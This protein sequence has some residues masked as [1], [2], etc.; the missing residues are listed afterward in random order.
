MRLKIK[1][2][3]K[4]I[5]DLDEI[6]EDSALNETENWDSINHLIIVT[7]L[8]ESFSIKFSIT[9]IEELTTLDK[10]CNKIKKMI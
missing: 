4:E 8:E 1:K 5:L 6:S 2:I 9:D 10:I 7:K 3:I